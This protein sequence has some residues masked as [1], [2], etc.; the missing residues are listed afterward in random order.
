MAQSID[1]YYPDRPNKPVPPSLPL[2]DYAGKYFHPGYLELKLE[3]VTDSTKL[4]RENISLVGA[5][6]DASWP[7]I[8]EF[9]H[10][11]GEYWMNFYYLS[12]NPDGPLK[13][14]A[15]AQFRIGPD[16]KV[17]ALGITWIV[18]EDGFDNPIQGLIWFDKVG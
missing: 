18:S 17:E 16:G 10:V 5:R 2:E 6:L 11:S 9:E 8:N 15:P 1:K 7:T 3:L 13:E 4:T 14:Y 12:T